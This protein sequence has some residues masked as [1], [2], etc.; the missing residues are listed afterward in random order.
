MCVC[1]L[2]FNS[3]GHYYSMVESGGTEKDDQSVLMAK[4][5]VDQLLPASP[6]IATLLS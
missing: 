6:L 1:F 2:R 4:E 3:L 5:K